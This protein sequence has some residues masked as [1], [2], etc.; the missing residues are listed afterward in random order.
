MAAL[1]N[2]VFE[3]SRTRLGLTALNLNSGGNF[4]GFAVTAYGPGERTVEPSYAYSPV[5]QPVLLY[6][7]AGIQTATLTVRIWGDP[8]TIKSGVE[9]LQQAF[10]QWEYTLTVELAD[11]TQMDILR[12]MPADVSIGDSGVWNKDAFNGGWQDVTAIIPHYPTF[13]AT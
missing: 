13:Y 3:V 4:S 1:T 10:G 9:T 6:H 11:S 7:Q 5:S 8:A 2:S 12:C